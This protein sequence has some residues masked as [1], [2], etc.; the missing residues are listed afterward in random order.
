MI[1]VDFKTEN[2]LFK[3]H[4]II[5]A[6]CSNAFEVRIS[7]QVY[8]P[9]STRSCCIMSARNFTRM[10]LSSSSRLHTL[11]GFL[12]FCSKQTMTWQTMAAS[13]DDFKLC[14]ENKAVM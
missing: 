14:S 8:L 12:K 13:F 3:L 6:P 9:M 2:R 1:I 7:Q 10:W 11:I 5:S 4:L